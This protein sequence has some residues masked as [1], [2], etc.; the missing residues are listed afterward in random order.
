[1]THPFEKA[2]GDLHQKVGFLGRGFND[3]KEEATR[4]LGAS[5]RD[6]D[7]MRREVSRLSGAL[8]QVESRSIGGS[9]SGGPGDAHV[10][11]IESIPGRRIP[12]DLLVDI[13][14]PT[15][16]VGEL[17]GT[18]TV[19]Q[20]GPFVAVARMASFL[21]AFQFQVRDPVTQALGTFVGRSSGRWRPISSVH[22]VNDASAGVFQPTVG[23]AFPGT[24][25]PIYA[26]PSN[27]SGFRSMEWD[28]FIEFLN[29]GSAY[30]RS[31]QLV[32]SVF[33]ASETSTAFQL[34]A[35]DFFERGETMQ[36]KIRPTHV[37]NPRAG[38][39]SGLAAGALF[40]FLDSQYDVQEGVNDPLNPAAT[41]DPASRL[42]DGFLTI[43][44]HGF[45][46]IQP[47]GVPRLA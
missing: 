1:M 27:M 36:W 17:Q 10:R 43:G 8:G 37:N 4:G 28:G 31:N 45:R 12:Y 2:L 42:P 39:V 19:T 40:P 14:I 29:Q 25:A 35:L 23:I 46:I 41:T 44:F 7:E 16:A 38:N 6:M 24:G 21:S 26:S 33:W 30:P 47:P 32:P 3:L 22:D 13:P 15:N 11:Y 20:D 5:R 34:G 18:R 9:G